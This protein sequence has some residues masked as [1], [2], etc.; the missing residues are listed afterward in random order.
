M[1]PSS[2][3]R[4]SPQRQPLPLAFLLIP[5]PTYTSGKPVLG[6][7]CRGALPDSSS[8]ICFFRS[9]VFVRF[10]P[11][12]SFSQLRSFLPPEAPGDRSRPRA[13][14]TCGEGSS[15]GVDKQRCC[16]PSP[17][18]L[19]TPVGQFLWTPT[20]GVLDVR[21]QHIQPDEMDGT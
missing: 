5:P 1:R 9:V 16:E 19:G 11:V 13:G 15:P 3:H 10:I 8:G 14:D 18:F 7:A 20:R 6:L 21:F 4:P 2:P 12:H 17:D